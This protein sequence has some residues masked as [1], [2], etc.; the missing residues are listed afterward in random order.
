MTYNE[1]EKKLKKAGCTWVRNVKRHPI[2][3]SPITGKQVELSYHGSR[4]VALGTLKSI[5]TDTG[6]KI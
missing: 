4:E 6:V 2:W 5:L 3:F 1:L